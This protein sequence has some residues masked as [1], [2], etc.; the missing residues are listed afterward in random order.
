MKKLF[1]IFVSILGWISYPLPLGD[2]QQQEQQSELA[3]ILLRLADRL[4]Q[5]QLFVELTLDNTVSY[6]ERIRIF[7][8]V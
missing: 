4:L 8:K 2:R 7:Q 5:L 3:R 6:K 1:R